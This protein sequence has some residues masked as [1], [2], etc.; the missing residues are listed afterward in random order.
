M[1]PSQVN[2]VQ[3]PAVAGD[4]ASD[5]PRFTVDAGPGALVAGALGVAVGLFGWSDANNQIVNNFGAGAPTGFV[6]R[7]QQ[8]LI[9]NFLAE[10]S[11]NIPQGLGLT[12]FSG[13]DFWVL[14]SGAAAVTIGQKAYANNATGAITFAATGTPPVG[15]SVTGSIAVNSATGSIAANS[16]T[17][18]IGGTTMTVTAVGAGGAYFAGQALSGTGVAVGTTIVRQLTGTLGSTGT[19][20]VSISQTT[21]ST[22]ITATGGTFTAASALTGTFAIGQTLTGTGIS[23]TTTIIGLISGAGGLGTY[24]VDVG[25]VVASTT[26]TASGGTL[27]VTATASGA[28]AL[29]DVISGSG[30]TAGT[31]VT[32]FVTGTGGNGTYLV[33]VSQTASS[34]AITVNAGFETKWIA[35]SNAGAGELV[36]MS[37][38]SLG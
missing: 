34:T 7:Q 10:A 3:A 32:K 26:I 22:T 5:N 23:Q 25:T 9:V 2:V 21:A 6:A 28:I 33:S 20:Q 14:N 31:Y 12:L 19:Y 36:K 30:V 35:T 18:S 8:A 29:N 11:N 17:A 13:G 27:T 15:A 16:G 1:F 24:A 37:S 38:H 4:F